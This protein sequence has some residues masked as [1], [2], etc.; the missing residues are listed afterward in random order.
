[1]YITNICIKVINSNIG[2]IYS[3]MEQYEKSL[4]Y[5]EKALEIEKDADDKKQIVASINNITLVLS[6]M[7]KYNEAVLKLQESLELAHGLNNLELIRSCY[8]N[9]L[10]IIKN[11]VILLTGIKTKPYFLILTG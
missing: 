11:L 2:M 9:C 3:D 5:F 4:I 10:I 6:Y 1:M 7:G 8:A